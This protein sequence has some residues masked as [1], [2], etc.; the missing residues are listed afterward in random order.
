MY[1]RVILEAPQVR[2][3]AVTTLAKMGAQVGVEEYFV[4]DSSKPDLGAFIA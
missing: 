1:N 3:A 2:A 4:I